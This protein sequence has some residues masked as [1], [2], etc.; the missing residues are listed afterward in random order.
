M[1]LLK[2]TVKNFGSYASLEFDFND[3]GLALVQGATGSGKST[4]QDLPAWILYGV[5]AKDGNADEIRSWTNP[6]EPTTGV[7]SVDLNGTI[8]T[9]SRTRGKASQNDLYWTE[10]D[11]EE[12]H[13]GK[14]LTETQRLLEA[15]LGV[16]K[17]LYIAGAY[18]NEFSPTG[19]FFT[20]KA[21]DRRELF[22]KLADL[23]LPKN[24]AERTAD[25]RKTKKKDLDQADRALHRA[26]DGLERS[27]RT[28]SDADN[29]RV[30]FSV[31]TA[32]N[33]ELL[34]RKS[35]NFEADKQEKIQ[36]AQAK[37]DHFDKTRLRNVEQ[38]N[39]SALSLEAVIRT[40]PDPQCPHCR[41][42]NSKVTRDI[43]RLEYIERS[44]AQTTAQPNPYLAE[45]IA[46]QN[47]VNHYNEQIEAEQ[48]KVNPFITQ[49]ESIG[50][51]IEALGQKVSQLT[52]QCSELEQNISNLTQ[53]ND[54]SFVLRKVLLARAISEIEVSTN[55]YLEKYF[56]SELR[57][58]FELEE[59]DDLNISITKNGYPGVYKQ[60]SKGQRQLL[61][62]SFSV[63][64]MKAAANRA[65]V[66]FGLLCFDEALDGM[67]GDL[68]IKAFSLFQELELSHKSILV[69]EHSTEFKQLF[70]REFTVTIEN[71][72]STIQEG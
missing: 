8:L 38:L 59:S 16:S 31:H 12:K 49:I 3:L 9:V 26:I 65:G 40:N 1:I 33:I 35:E 36:K 67:D 5:T 13:R 4:L 25:V 43:C 39:E 20:A 47:L 64:I 57:V 51:E 54:L 42:V 55:R 27:K 19:A 6:D 10:G 66:H 29:R 15:R 22:E 41:Q 14:D 58:K 52:T 70:S 11:A 23:E 32:R 18:Y 17:D 30:E 63:S 37:I 21:K 44:I 2:A 72:V 60:L 34:R 68:K 28:L 48:A 45:L 56:D 46:C 53:L 71:D 24:I 69:V 50:T 61:K 7:I 62:L